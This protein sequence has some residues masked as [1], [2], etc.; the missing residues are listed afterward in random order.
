[1]LRRPYIAR[2][3]R[4]AMTRRRRVQTWRGVPQLCAFYIEIPARGSTL[5]GRARLSKLSFLESATSGHD[6]EMR[7][8]ESRKSLR[9][10]CIPPDSRNNRTSRET[11]FLNR[12]KR[13]EYRGFLDSF[14]DTRANLKFEACTRT[15]RHNRRATYTYEGP[16]AKTCPISR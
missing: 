4:P 11:F 13:S 7:S 1:M 9:P 10:S 15:V 5:R 6:A 8:I 3:R 12:E 16:A 2:P 14:E